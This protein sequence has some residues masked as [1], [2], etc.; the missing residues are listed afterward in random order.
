MTWHFMKLNCRPLTLRNN[1]TPYDAAYVALAEQLGGPV[2][3][4]DARLASA[5]GS[6]CAFELIG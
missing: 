4:C 2:L 6:R 3:T 1:V 5:S